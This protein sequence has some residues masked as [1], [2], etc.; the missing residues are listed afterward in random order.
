MVPPHPINGG[1]VTLLTDFGLSDTYVGVMKG[2]L[3]RLAPEATIIDLT[4]EVSPQ[5]VLQGSFLLEQAHQHFPSGTVHLVVVDPGVGTA[6]RRLAIASADQFYVGPDNGVL[7]AAVQA[8]SRGERRVDELY[9]TRDIMLHAD[10]LAVS[11]DPAN[12]GAIEISATFEGRDVFAP[13]AAHL[14][15]GGR[16]EALGT[17]TISMHAYPAFE[18]PEHEGRL[19]GLVLHT[20]HYGNL[21]TD[22]RGEDLPDHPVIELAGRRLELAT[23]YEDAPSLCAIIGSSGYVEVSLSNGSAANELKVVRGEPVTAHETSA[24]EA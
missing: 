16:I 15:R 8:W 10:L 2:V 4:H 6:R 22:I 23:T 7:S 17:R 11:I 21:I 20:D 5:D 19:D 9:A 12:L 1:T 3:R 13:A 18:A 14:A 24:P